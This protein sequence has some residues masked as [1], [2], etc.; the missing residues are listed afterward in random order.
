MSSK[1]GQRFIQS[2]ERLQAMRVMFK[3]LEDDGSI[4]Y[5]EKNG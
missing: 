3:E 2:L 1:L 5:T 4:Y